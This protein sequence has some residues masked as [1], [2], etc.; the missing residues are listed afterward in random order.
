MNV[1]SGSFTL[2]RVWQVF[3]SLLD[4]QKMI[5]R[6]MTYYLWGNN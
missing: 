2:P 1:D 4:F 3:I 6:Q 5:T